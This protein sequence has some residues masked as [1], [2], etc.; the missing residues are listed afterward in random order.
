MNTARVYIFFLIGS[1]PRYK[2]KLRCSKTLERRAR[3]HKKRG[4]L[5]L[6]I[7]FQVKSDKAKVFQSYTAATGLACKPRIMQSMSHTC[8]QLTLFQ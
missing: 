5:E 2:V 8:S 3:Q 4:S 1:T 6:Q 7:E